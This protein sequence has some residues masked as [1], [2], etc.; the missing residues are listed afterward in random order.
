[1]V[2]KRLE[3]AVDATRASYLKNNIL[4]CVIS[5][6]CRDVDEI[7]AL[8]GCYAAIVPTFRDKLSVPPPRVKKSANLDIL[9]VHMHTKL[10]VNGV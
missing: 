9:V 5:G 4:V 7:C 2:T 6:F 8:L 10:T 1:M 3:H